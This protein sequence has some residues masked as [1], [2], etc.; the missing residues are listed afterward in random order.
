M[1]RKTDGSALIKGPDSTEPALLM[2]MAIG[3]RAA[4]AAVTCRL[5]STTSVT[6]A[7]PHPAASLAPAKPIRPEPLAACDTF[8]RIRGITA[9]V[10]EHLRWAG[11]T[12]YTEI[13]AWSAADVDR[14]DRELGRHGRIARDNWIEQAQILSKGG[15]TAFSRAFDRRPPEAPLPAPAPAKPR[16]RASAAPGP[17]PRPGLLG[18]LRS[19]R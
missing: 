13:A 3:P 19:V 18:A 1:V 11:V 9:T 5:T 12:R 8:E 4:S 10:A 6:S 17:Q 14:F 7:T 16:P 15:D 2:R